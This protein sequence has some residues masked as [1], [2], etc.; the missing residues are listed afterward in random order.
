MPIL[1]SSGHWASSVVPKTRAS[2]SEQVVLPSVA[3]GVMEKPSGRVT[4]A[5]LS[6]E[7]EGTV[8]LSN[9]GTVRRNSAPEGVSAAVVV[10][11]IAGTG[12]KVSW[13]QSVVAG[14]GMSASVSPPS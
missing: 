4:S 11:S 13:S 9:W 5:A 12:L 7:G 14:Q 8:G 1:E 6:S 2:A 3:L 10:G